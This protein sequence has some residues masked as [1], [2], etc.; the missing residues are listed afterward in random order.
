[1]GIEYVNI[2]TPHIVS[3]AS[4]CQGKITAKTPGKDISKQTSPLFTRSITRIPA[5]FTLHIRLNFIYMHRLEISEQSGKPN[6]VFD[7]GYG[8][9]LRED[10]KGIGFHDI[11]PACWKKGH[12]PILSVV[13]HPPLPPALAAIHIFKLQSPPGVKR[14]RHP[15]IMF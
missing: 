3:I 2:I 8:L 14:V 10:H 9:P 11:G 15:K 6:Q 13:K 7:P 5:L 1:L 4:I 12:L